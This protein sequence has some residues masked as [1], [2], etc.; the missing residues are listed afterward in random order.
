M[1]N[2]L[3][4]IIEDQVQ[5]AEVITVPIDATLSISGEAADAKA[6]GDALAQ[7]ADKSEIQTAVTVNGQRADAQGSIIVT[8][9]D[10]KISDSDATTVKA[11][12]DIQ[13]LILRILCLENR[14]ANHIHLLQNIRH[15]DE[16]ICMLHHNIKPLLNLLRNVQKRLFIHL[17]HRDH[18]RLLSKGGMPLLRLTPNQK[19]AYDAASGDIS[20]EQ[21]YAA[22]MIR[23]QY[24]IVTFEN[25]SVEEIVRAI[26]E[27]YGIRVTASG[28]D[29]SK[30]YHMSFLRSDAPGDVL[31]VLE[32]LTGGHFS[33]NNVQ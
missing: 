18:S 5:A 15:T 30:Q 19:A 32:L 13:N 26:E 25:A 10:T 20:V 21:V 28:Y 29:P 17:H 11:A 7:K 4:V 14:R 9:E 24:S 3:N 1:A 23:Q 12:I 22:P 31:A 27:N 8:A 33:S 6:V 2:D 16:N